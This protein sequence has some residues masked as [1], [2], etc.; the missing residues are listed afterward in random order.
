MRI[1]HSHDLVDEALDKYF[2]EAEFGF[3]QPGS[4]ESYLVELG[5]ES[6]VVISNSRHALAVYEITPDGQPVRIEKAVDWPDE[7]MLEGME[8]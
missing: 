1:F 4:G 3:A 7:I 6:F 5:E 8:A 2:A